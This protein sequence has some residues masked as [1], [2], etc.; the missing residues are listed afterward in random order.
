MGIFNPIVHKNFREPHKYKIIFI[1]AMA[2]SGVTST[3]DKGDCFC[4]S[5]PGVLLSA[6]KRNFPFDSVIAV[7]INVNK[8]KTLEKRLES[9]DMPT[10]INVI[11]KD[12]NQCYKDIIDL[13][14]KEK[15]MSYTII[16]PE[17]YE[18]IH[19]NTIVS[20]ISLRGDSMLTW[21]EHDVWRMRGAALSKETPANTKDSD[22]KRL[23]E[24]FG[25]DYWQLAKSKQNL[26]K[27]FIERLL[28][29]TGKSVAETIT[30]PR[31]SGEFQ[32]ILFTNESAKHKANEW[33]RRVSEK[34]NSIH[35][36]SISN[37]LDVKTGRNTSL[38][39]FMK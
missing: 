6:T 12:I 20:L 3:R 23:N 14:N 17:G 7:E 22:I 30:I 38:I 32:L 39:D 2:G 18:G 15:S 25:G 11:P 4:G 27:L 33:A 21:F 37:L 34:I 8:A 29:S 19:W 36:Q 1:D 31:T 24:I 9:I 35:G 13:V 26:T 16:D 5:C 28:S 10:D